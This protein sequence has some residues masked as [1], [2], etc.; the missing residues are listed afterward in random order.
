[1]LDVLIEH[2]KVLVEHVATPLDNCESGSACCFYPFSLALTQQ[3][4]LLITYSIPFA[5][6]EV[7]EGGCYG[8]LTEEGSTAPEPSTTLAV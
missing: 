2:G 5:V 7:E 3:H 1:M 4:Q 6:K 8:A